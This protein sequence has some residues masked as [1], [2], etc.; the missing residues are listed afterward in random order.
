MGFPVESCLQERLCENVNA[1]ISCRTISTGLEAVGYLTWTFFYRRVRANPSYYGAVS[2]S[3]DDV[4]ALLVQVMTATLENLRNHGC[5]VYDGDVMVSDIKS[6]TLGQAACNYYLTYRTPYQMRNGLRQAQKLVKEESVRELQNINESTGED[7]HLRPLDIPTRHDEV[8]CSWL[9]YT[10]SSTHEFD[11]LPVRH[12][13]EYLNRDLSQRLMWGPD[14]SSLVSG[15]ATQDHDLDIFLDP[16]TK[17]FL[18][19]QAHL[20]RA[21]LPISDYVNDTKSVVDNLPRLLAAMQFIANDVANVDHSLD[22][23]TQIARTKQLVTTRSMPHDDPLL[24]LPGFDVAMVRRLK[25]METAGQALTIYELRRLERL[26]AEGIFM[27]LRKPEKGG[28]TQFPRNALDEMYSMPMMRVGSIEARR[29]GVHEGDNVGVLSLSLGVEQHSRGGT[30]GVD[31]DGDKAG[32][33]GSTLNI[34][35]GSLKQ[36]FLLAQSS[37]S[38]AGS[39]TRAAELTFD[40]EAAKADGGAV[41]V[42]FVYD[43]L[44]GFDCEAVVPLAEG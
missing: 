6:T 26:E 35:V 20:E 25:S 32:R 14:P 13:E 12:N 34:L 5:A 39:V 18:L 21:K 44:R 15:V 31:R 41:L 17:C 16:H 9:L 28:S 27:K 10:I 1:E 8:A 33:L 24:Q 38:I 36:R 37:I 2:S 22:V 23:A 7:F 30:N 11:E 40:W 43:E 42:R 4:H 3:E 29:K 19:I